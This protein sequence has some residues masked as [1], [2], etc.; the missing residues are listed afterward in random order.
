MNNTNKNIMPGDRVRVFCSRLYVND[1]VTPISM[2][3]QPATV[4]CRYGKKSIY[5]M[6]CVHEYNVCTPDVWNYPDLVDVIFDMFPNMV[7]R[8]HFT[9]SVECIQ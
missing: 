7:S 9:S 8:G 6:N 4:V 1:I 2:T 5:H 3:M